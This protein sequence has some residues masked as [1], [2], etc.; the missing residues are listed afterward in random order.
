MTRAPLL[1]AA[2]FASIATGASATGAGGSALERNVYLK[3]GLENSKI[4]A[5]TNSTGK[6]IT[7]G[8]KISFSALRRGSTAYFDGSF[9]SPDMVPGAAIKRPAV[10][11]VSCTAW[12]VKPLLMQAP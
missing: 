9:L 12:Y 5:V 6:I 10:D 11:S 2:V 7:A 8:T 3:C 1:L 4:V